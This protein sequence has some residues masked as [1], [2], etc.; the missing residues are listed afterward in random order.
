MAKKKQK[1]GLRTLYNAYVGP[2]VSGLQVYENKSIMDLE[3]GQIFG[4]IFDTNSSSLV[5]PQYE[6][7]DNGNKKIIF[8]PA[9]TFIRGSFVRADRTYVPLICK[10]LNGCFIED[11]LTGLKFAVGRNDKT[12]TFSE[13]ICKHVDM[14][15]INQATLDFRQAPIILDSYI[16][17]RTNQL[18][19]HDVVFVVND[20]FKEI[21]GKFTLLNRDEVIKNLQTI[22]SNAKDIFES[23]LNDCITSIHDMAIAE[24]FLRSNGYTLEKKNETTM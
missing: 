3:E 23:A 20:V 5:K 2:E 11:L 18:N 16:Q 12:T 22:D 7:D 6:N 15:G 17:T 13:N 21:F 10:K 4:I 19:L 24:N 9:V 14:V 8:N 1:E